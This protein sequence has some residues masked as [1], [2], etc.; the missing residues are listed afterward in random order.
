MTIFLIS[1]WLRRVLGATGICLTWAAGWAVAGLLT[2]VASLLLP[3][4]PW[5]SFFEIYDA[6]LPTLAMPGFIGAAFFSTLVGLV[7]NRSRFEDLSLAG[8]AAWGAAAGLLLSLVP[9]GM[10]TVGLAALNRPEGLCKLTTAISG[11]LI[12]LGAASGAGLLLLAR[13]AKPWRTLIGY[14]LA[15][16]QGKIQEGGK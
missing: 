4:L 15:S 11:P 5:D 14:L 9:A 3:G 8:F 16:D 7:K 13:V 6:P 10:V 1:N 12:F 2:G